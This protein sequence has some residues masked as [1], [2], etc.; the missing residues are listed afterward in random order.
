MG[1]PLILYGLRPLAN[2]SFEDDAT[3]P[4]GW[5]AAGAGAGHLVVASPVH[6]AGDGI[7]SVLALQQGVSS[8]TTGNRAV[9]T[10]R[11]SAA[12][13]PSWMR[14]ASG[15][16]SPLTP[17]IGA[18]AMLNASDG[19][20]ARFASL[21]LRQYSGGD[22]TPA[23]G[24][25]ITPAASRRAE[26]ALPAAAWR[27][28]FAAIA[29]A[30]AA[31]WIDVELSFDPAAG[32]WRSSSVAV[33]DRVFLGC[34]ADLRRGFTKWDL[35]TDGGVVLNQGNGVAELVKVCRPT[36][37]ITAELGAVFAD[38]PDDAAL[39][40]MIRWSNGSD[41]GYMAVW[42]DRERHLNE[43]QHYQRVAWADK[44]SP[45]YQPGVLRRTYALTLVAP[46]EA[47]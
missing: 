9:L 20:A 23:S 27:M 30:P 25:E 14:V 43:D 29:L 33:W 17:E 39:K 15:A 10:Q 35:E 32:G 19:G 37:T 26:Y 31:D 34:V 8:A 2:A 1:A 47:S 28:R 42:L 21:R 24:A 4:A 40:R 3:G 12:A 18:T 44:R 11:V 6:S 45:S 38:S 5:T 16:A 22:A 13:I 36:T 7:P 41:P 46:V